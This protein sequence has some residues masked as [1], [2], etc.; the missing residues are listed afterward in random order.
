[1]RA[2]GIRFGVVATIAVACLVGLS[3]GCATTRPAGEQV[4][5]SW[6]TSKISSKLAA[7]PQVSAAEVD[8]DT[9]NGV[10]TL[11]GVVATDEERQEAVQLAVDTRG[12]VR[13]INQIE[14]GDPTPEEKLS[15]TWIATKIK[16]KLTVDPQ[17][18][19]FDI[20]VDVNRGVVTLSGI[21]RSKEQRAE[22]EKLARSTR[23]VER[24]D[25]LLTV[26]GDR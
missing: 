10:V 24:V 23:G 9:E 1:M 13:V 16:T 14:L 4:N 3:A 5:D 20:D 2:D 7:D 6:I 15:D 12:V 19:P 11:R 26:K 21:V 25:N 18:N 22:A 17:V 8:V